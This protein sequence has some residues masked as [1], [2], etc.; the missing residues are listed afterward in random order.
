MRLEKKDEVAA[1]EA[2]DEKQ[3]QRKREEEQE[4]E[5]GL[6][7]EKEGLGPEHTPWLFQGDAV[8]T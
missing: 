1:E 3:Y 8:M 5:E 6:G 4:G 7:R 2:E